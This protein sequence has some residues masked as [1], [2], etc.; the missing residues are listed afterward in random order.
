MPPFDTYFRQNKR[1]TN[2]LTDLVLYGA[3]VVAV[4]VPGDAVWVPVPGEVEE[5]AAP[6][7]VARHPTRAAVSAALSIH[8]TVGKERVW[9]RGVMNPL[10][11]GTK[12]GSRI[13]KG[14]KIRLPDPWPESYHVTY[15]ADGV[16]GPQEIERN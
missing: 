8:S 7:Q 11:T 15:R 2:R 3:A 12:S 6:D 9:N 13:A 16:D 10:F 4:V 14:L 5:E 1:H